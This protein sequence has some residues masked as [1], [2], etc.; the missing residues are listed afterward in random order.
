MTVWPDG[1]IAAFA[2]AV[3]AHRLVAAV[4]PSLAPPQRMGWPFLLVLLAHLAGQTAAGWAG[5]KSESGFSRRLLAFWLAPGVFVGFLVLLALERIGFAA[6]VTCIF[7]WVLCSGRGVAFVTQPRNSQ[8]AK[9]DLVL[10]TMILGFLSLVVGGSSQR[11]FLDIIVFVLLGS[12][13]LVLRRSREVS[14]SSLLLEENAPWAIGGAVFIGLVLVAVLIL[15]ALGPGGSE[16]VLAVFR[17]L[18]EWF[19]TILGYLMIPVAYL[20]QWL[21]IGFQRMIAGRN[22]ETPE[23]QIPEP[24]DLLGEL[25]DEQRLTHLPEWVK[26]AVFLVVLFFVGHLVWRFVSKSFSARESEHARETRTSLAHGEAPK[27][28]L[29]EA[30][31][32]LAAVTSGVMAKLRSLI[33]REPRTLE[34]LYRAT[35]MLLAA[36]G[37]S[38]DPQLTPYEYRDLVNDDIPVEEGREA[39]NQI[40]AIFAECFYSERPPREEELILAKSAYGRILGTQFRVSGKKT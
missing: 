6:M 7:A 19:A 15:Y 32:G 26:W 2:E 34:G 17:I 16:A 3:I 33:D 10:G 25:L 30:L 37:L 21:I 22:M 9:R 35:L 12:A 28:W 1:V 36:R 5:S 31:G 24:D 4:S 18:W 27:E 29:A 8:T 20:V 40:T 23:A 11:A 13:L 39:L 14:D 38:K